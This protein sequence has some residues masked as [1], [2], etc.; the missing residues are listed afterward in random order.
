M[1]DRSPYGKPQTLAN[2]MSSNAGETS[3]HFQVRP[4]V[5]HQQPS[6]PRSVGASAGNLSLGNHSVDGRLA[7]PASSTQ[8]TSIAATPGSAF[9]KSSTSIV[10]RLDDF[11]P[12]EG[13]IR[14][15]APPRIVS[16]AAPSTSHTAGSGS[17]S[18]SGA[19]SGAGSA[20]ASTSTL[21]S[22]NDSAPLQ[23]A[24]PRNPGANYKTNL[25][26]GWNDSAVPRA[27][28]SINGNANGGSSGS[29]LDRVTG[30]PGAASPSRTNSNANGNGT[31]AGGLANRIGT[32]RY[33]P[34]SERRSR[35][36]SPHRASSIPL[37]DRMPSISHDRAPSNQSSRGPTP[38]LPLT[39]NPPGATTATTTSTSSTLRDRLAASISSSKADRRDDEDYVDRRCRSLLERHSELDSINPHRLRV[40]TVSN[41]PPNVSRDDVYVNME[42]YGDID[43]LS[44]NS[45]HAQPGQQQFKS[46]DVRFKHADD[47]ACAVK[48]GNMSRF[49][50][51]S[52]TSQ[53]YKI[54]KVTFMK[55]APPGGSSTSSS[56]PPKSAVSSS[57]TATAPNRKSTSSA[58]TSAPPLVP[59]EP[60]A[61]KP[62]SATARAPETAP[63]V[64]GQGSLASASAPSRPLAPKPAVA[65]SSRR[66][67]SGTPPLPSGDQITTPARPASA[68]PLPSQPAVTVPPGLSAPAPVVPPSVARSVIDP[69]H[70]RIVFPFSKFPPQSG[71]TN[72]FSSA[73]TSSS[74][75]EPAASKGGAGAPSASANGATSAP[76]APET[77]QTT[78]SSTPAPVST[79]AAAIP[80]PTPAS[81]TSNPAPSPV[82]EPQP[83]QLDKFTVCGHDF[84][85][86]AVPPGAAA[87]LPKTATLAFSS[88]TYKNTHTSIG[89]KIG[90]GISLHLSQCGFVVMRISWWRDVKAPKP[91]QG[92]MIAQIVPKSAPDQIMR[93]ASAAFNNANSAPPAG[94]PI[95]VP[96]NSSKRPRDEPRTGGLASSTV[97]KSTAVTSSDKRARIGPA[98]MAPATPVEDVPMITLDDDV[99]IVRIELPESARGP[100]PAATKARKVLR[101]Q[102]TKRINSEGTIVLSAVFKGDVLEIAYEVDDDDE[103]EVEGDVAQPSAASATPQQPAPAVLATRR[104]SSVSNV[105]EDIK[106][107]KNALSRVDPNDEELDM[108]MSEPEIPEP[109]PVYFP[110]EIRVVCTA[111]S[112]ETQKAVESFIDDFFTRFD[113]DRVSLQYLYHLESAFS[114]R[115]VPNVPPR[116]QGMYEHVHPF[117]RKFMVAAGKTYLTPT[118]IANAI[119]KLPA[120]SHDIGNLIYDARV[121]SDLRRGLPPSRLVPIVLH[122][123]GTFEE[124]PEHIVRKITRT[125]VLVPRDASTGGL[126]MQ[127]SPYVIKTDQLVFSHYDPKA[128]T[129][130]LVDP[131]QGPFVKNQGQGSGSPKKKRV[132]E[133]ANTG[134]PSM[135]NAPIS[136]VPSFRKQTPLQPL[137]QAPVPG[138][139]PPVPVASDTGGSESVEPNN[140]PVPQAGPSNPT[141]APAPGLAPSLFS[142]RTTPARANPD[143]LVISDSSDDSDSG[144]DAASSGTPEPVS[145]PRV[146]VHSPPNPLQGLPPPILRP[147]GTSESSSSSRQESMPVDEVDDDDDSDTPDQPSVDVGK[148]KK[149]KSAVTP[150][151]TSTVTLSVQQ[152]ER[153]VAK[154]VRAVMR[155]QERERERKKKRKRRRA[156]SD[157]DDKD[158]D[159]DDDDGNEDDEEGDSDVVIAGGQLASVSGHRSDVSSTAR[160]KKRSKDKNHSVAAS[161]ANLASPSGSDG[162]IAISIGTSAMPH[163]YDGKSNKMRWMIDIGSSFLGVSMWGDV[164][165][166]T[167]KAGPN[168]VRKLHESK[169]KTFAVDDIAFSRNKNVLIVPYLGGK[170]D[171][172]GTAPKNQVTLYER[173]VDRQGLSKVIE[174]PLSAQPH[175]RG[176]ITATMVLPGA[177]SARLQFITA[178]EDK[179]MYLWTRARSDR[180][181]STERL[182]CE[183]TSTITSLDHLASDGWLISGGAD[184]RVVATNIEQRRNMWSALLPN[185][186]YSVEPSPINPH[187]ILARQSSSSDQF[188]LYDTRQSGAGPAVLT[189]G[190]PLAPRAIST[191]SVPVAP[192]L[193]RYYAGSP[194]REF[195]YAFPDLQQ[196][197]KLWD[198]RKATSA[199]GGGGSGS[200]SLVPR[201]QSMHGVASSKVV[202]VLCRNDELALMEQ[203]GFTSVRIR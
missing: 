86:A 176:G 130:L 45:D 23:I 197:V 110:R 157:S 77:P 134:P 25:A 50:V 124:F 31:D 101:K 16:A 102:H 111:D 15:S 137:A 203:Q 61:S 145:R 3:Y 173:K 11:Q 30:G 44:I 202:Q 198:L 64:V 154:Q 76:S 14:T 127:R 191:S 159:E 116:M 69:Q 182:P 49:W 131:A 75:A 9:S 174:S 63:A 144:S 33:S 73:P 184:K 92:L 199:I 112:I 5:Y 155:E 36:S 148:K 171:K 17:G 2:R 187:L 117:Q 27:L 54:V 41:L 196:G 163:G 181:I 94:I 24:R 133:T 186:V 140:A 18:G 1:A 34:T 46:A 7:R 32:S 161:A 180:S 55:P 58:P 172:A 150:A 66:S 114:V 195:A 175:G 119:V 52:A 88:P 179:M 98:P 152:M 160:A 81:A 4:K 56:L 78:V 135:G 13:T 84:V 47:A 122:L 169:G 19:G 156:R 132:S 189:F 106:P 162:R 83:S 8:P 37:K 107:D 100:T 43:C 147:R 38:P 26:G 170:I 118:A 125:F 99:R 120:G 138:P 141:P 164:I 126:N 72:P 95:A 105:D 51:R 57:A 80:E 177:A 142:A 60:A 35:P 90:N 149:K 6:V 10:H 39:H 103:E 109:D 79:A 165:E 89:S 121:V 85:K 22:Y 42:L 108:I 185:P 200:S 183:H 62:I 178:G 168:A 129:Q 74:M 158:A 190:F 128:P 97:S 48:I 87:V 136:Q 67:S 12:N 21:S 167:G 82:A 96:S 192:N 146:P 201:M 29:L 139:E 151:A 194:L 40:V 20:S 28:I 71:S 59:T 53:F 91:G 143:V 65:R 153:L 104:E 93:M 115:V 113:S 123:H 166:W 188:R 193:G 68:L 70:P